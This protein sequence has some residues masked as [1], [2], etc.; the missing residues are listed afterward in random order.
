M[1]FSAAKVVF[2]WKIR[3]KIRLTSNSLIVTETFAMISRFLKER[4]SLNQ[5][6]YLSFINTFV[7]TQ[8]KEMA[9]EEGDRSSA[10]LSPK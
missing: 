9:D 6:H 7:K 2:V 3:L 1:L 5:V 8:Q 4:F 10:T